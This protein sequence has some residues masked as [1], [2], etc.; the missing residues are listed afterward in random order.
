M[1]YVGYVYK[2][3][4]TVTSKIYIGITTRDINVRWN[5]HKNESKDPGNNHFH[6]A[7]K[8]TDGMLLKNLF[9]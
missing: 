9:Q 4:C 8:N 7:I 3:Y 2:I 5:Q 1:K 6:L